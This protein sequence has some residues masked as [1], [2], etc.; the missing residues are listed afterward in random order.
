MRAFLI[1]LVSLLTMSLGNPLSQ[2][3][4]KV[5]EARSTIPHGFVNQGPASPATILRMRFALKQ[6]DPANL[7]DTVLAVSTPGSACYGQHLSK[8]EV[9]ST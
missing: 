1:T 8:N 4:M 3:M 9:R 6:S 2:R 5:H 7:E